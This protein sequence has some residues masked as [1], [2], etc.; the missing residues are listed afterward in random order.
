MMIITK[1]VLKYPKTER[2]HV[3]N[4]TKTIKLNAFFFKIE[5]KIHTHFKC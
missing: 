5:N 4:K 2:A 3:Q 1:W